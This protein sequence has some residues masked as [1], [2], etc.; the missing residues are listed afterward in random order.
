MREDCRCDG[1]Y[2]TISST[3]YALK[4]YS[5]ANDLPDLILKSNNKASSLTYKWNKLQFDLILKSDDDLQF[6]TF[7]LVQLDITSPDLCIEVDP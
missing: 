2:P 6:D 3:N 5:F 1:Y 4:Y 7:K